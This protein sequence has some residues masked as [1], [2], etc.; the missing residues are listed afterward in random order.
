MQRYCNNG[1]ENHIIKQ[2][3]QG[4]MRSS[5]L[6]LLLIEVHCVSYTFRNLYFRRPDFQGETWSCKEQ[7]LTS[8]GGQG[9]RDGLTELLVLHLFLMLV[10][11]I[12]VLELIGHRED[13]Y[14]LFRNEEKPFPNRNLILFIF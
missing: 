10:R 14:H 1:Q 6:P 8:T 4:N 5:Y 3:A 13:S 2:I 9:G 7:W 12:K 11:V